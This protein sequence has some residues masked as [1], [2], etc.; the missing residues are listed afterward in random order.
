DLIQF[1]NG[2][3]RC[4]SVCFMLYINPRAIEAHEQMLRDGF[5]DALPGFVGLLESQAYQ[6]E[7]E[8][9]GMD[10]G[11]YIGSLWSGVQGR[12]GNDITSRVEYRGIDLPRL[13]EG[14]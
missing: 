13:P 7:G 4:P 6:S 1:L 3:A 9:S 14:V 5:D 10:Y 8:F 2:T 12:A 11:Y